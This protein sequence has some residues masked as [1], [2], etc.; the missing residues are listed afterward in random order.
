MVILLSVRVSWVRE[1]GKYFNPALWPFGSLFFFFFLFLCTM[2]HN[3]V[4][5]LQQTGSGICIDVWSLAAPT[6]SME[7]IRCFL[8]RVFR[9]VWPTECQQERP[10]RDSCLGSR[11]SSGRTFS[12]MR[13]NTPGPRASAY[14]IGQGL[15]A[16]GILR[17]EGC[18]PWA[19]PAGVTWLHKCWCFS[20]P[21]RLPRGKCGNR[22]TGWNEKY[23]PQ[24]LACIAC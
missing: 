24:G 18:V 22:W 10:H 15:G 16:P 9:W 4:I 13:G 6:H 3:T 2:N 12:L 14:G 7:K 21:R 1:G 11:F 19:R 23:S 20:H 8:H 5:E 17:I